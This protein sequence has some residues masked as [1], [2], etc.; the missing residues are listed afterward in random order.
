MI[1]MFSIAVR[2][3]CEDVPV[4]CAFTKLLNL[5]FFGILFDLVEM[6]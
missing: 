2:D 5:S 4:K 3:K 6:N 1:I